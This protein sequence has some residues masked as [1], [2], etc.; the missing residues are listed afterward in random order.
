MDAR[1]PV[2]ADFDLPLPEPAAVARRAIDAHGYSAGAYF[3]VRVARERRW[4]RIHVG[5]LPVT[6]FTLFMAIG[7]F[8]HL[9]RFD[10]QHV[11]FW[12][13]VGLYVT[14]PGLVPL[15]W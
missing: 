13:W 12:I 15:V 6:A 8:N 11:A 4:H 14:P 1:A 2:R 5:F 9:D 7:T 3:F 10:P